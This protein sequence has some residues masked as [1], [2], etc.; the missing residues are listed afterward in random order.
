M[1][2]ISWRY[3]L[4]TQEA[5][6]YLQQAEQVFEDVTKGKWGEAMSFTEVGKQMS[7]SAEYGRKLCHKAL[8]KL[9]QAAE[10][11]TLEPALLF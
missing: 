4:V 6:S 8:E 3:G 7:C 5:P 1:E 9:R 10:A 2:A 11:G